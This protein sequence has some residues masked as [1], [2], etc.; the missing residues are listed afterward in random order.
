MGENPTLTWGKTLPNNL[1]SAKGT[2]SHH[3]ENQKPK[4]KKTGILIRR[5]KWSRLLSDAEH[6][7]FEI[8]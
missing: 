5:T 4:N 6:Q 8:P 1:K 3:L 7:N 2:V